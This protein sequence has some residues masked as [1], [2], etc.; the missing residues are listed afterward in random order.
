LVLNTLQE[1]LNKQDSKS[2][3][4]MEFEVIMI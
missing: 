2:T 1:L 4:R 3:L